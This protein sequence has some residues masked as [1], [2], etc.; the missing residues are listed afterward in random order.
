[1]TVATSD[2][3]TGALFTV[4]TTMEFSWAGSVACPLTS[5]SSSWWFSSIWPG[6][7]TTFELRTASD[8]C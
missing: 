8:T 7:A 5:T 1:M 2:T 4:A 6:D 3:L